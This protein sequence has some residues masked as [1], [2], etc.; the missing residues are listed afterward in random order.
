M[1]W[2]VARSDDSA[3]FEE[4]LRSVQDQLDLPDYYRDPLDPNNRMLAEVLGS[5]CG[6][7]RSRSRRTSGLVV[8]LRQSRGRGDRRARF[9]ARS[10][11]GAATLWC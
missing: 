5:R 8:P 10:T 7:R 6:A 9:V 1:L 3:R 11:T 4:W 2:S